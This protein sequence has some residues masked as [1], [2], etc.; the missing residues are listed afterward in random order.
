MDNKEKTKVN[1]G[2]ACSVATCTYNDNNGHCLAN[3]IA[4]GPSSAT[5]CADTVCA[6]YRPRDIG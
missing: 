2:I 6:T 3:K 4:V 1:K 5:C